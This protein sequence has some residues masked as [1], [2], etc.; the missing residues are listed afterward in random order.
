MCCGLG[1]WIFNLGVSQLETGFFE[2]VAPVLAFLSPF[3][4]SF[5]RALPVW[6]SV[7]MPGCSVIPERAFIRV[8]PR[9]GPAGAYSME[10]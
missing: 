7:R 9:P 3:A 6:T 1:H 8:S 4:E 2:P 10:K 5:V